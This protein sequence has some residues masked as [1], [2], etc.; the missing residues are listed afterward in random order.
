MQAPEQEPAQLFVQPTEQT[1]PQ[2]PL[3]PYVHPKSQPV[4][5]SLSCAEVPKTGILASAIAPRIGNAFFAAF[6]KKSRRDWSSSLPS[7]LLITTSLYVPI[8][9]PA[10]ARIIAYMYL[11]KKSVEVRTCHSSHASRLS[12]CPVL[13]NE[14][15]ETPTPMSLYNT[16][17]TL[18]KAAQRQHI[19]KEQRRLYK[20]PMSIYP[21]PCPDKT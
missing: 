14:Q 15:R 6:L 8:G 7:F 10:S 18:A 20:H 3:Q 5:S 2:P 21:L 11:H 1:R 12:H 16:S 9:L 19:R 4:S 13:L 17:L